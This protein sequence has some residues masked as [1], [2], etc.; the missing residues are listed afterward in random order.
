MSVYPY[1]FAPIYKEKIW[2]GRALERCFGRRLPPGLKIGESWELADLPPA[3]KDAE[4]AS[5]VANGPDGGR[6]ITALLGEKPDE[7]LGAAEPWEDERFP[8]LLKVLDAN[9]VL[10]LQVHPD[11]KVAAEMGGAVR[12]KTECWYVLKS[13]GGHLLKG[14]KPGVT[15]EEFRRAIGDDDALRALIQRVE[16]AEGQ[17]HYLPAGTVHALGAGVVVAE[18]Q[19]PSD[20]TF[21]ISDWGRG[22]EVHVEEALRSIH[23]APLPTKPPGAAGDVLLSTPY[24]TV[25]RCVLP[26]GRSELIVGRCAAWMVLAGMGHILSDSPEPSVTVTSLETVLLP[27]GLDRGDLVVEEEMKFLEI[28]LQQS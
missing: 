21:R 1:K 26:P 19:T 3:D 12:P 9:E 13:F 15:A 25:R 16:A 20:T 14:V 27:A 6:S 10:S 23:F 4:T 2:G 7:I 8:L 22:R 5:V 24:F 11:W 18:I 17:F 28:T